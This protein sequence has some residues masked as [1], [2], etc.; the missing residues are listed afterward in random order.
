MPVMQA[1]DENPSC[2]SRMAAKD[3]TPA[4]DAPEQQ[5]MM[6]SGAGCDFF[7]AFYRLPDHTSEHSHFSHTE[8]EP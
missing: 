4:S 3:R 2:A 6:R 7:H 5:E 8:N 1:K